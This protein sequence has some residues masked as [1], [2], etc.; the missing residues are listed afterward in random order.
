MNLLKLKKYKEIVV[1]GHS[2][3]DIDSIVSSKILSEILSNYGIKSHYAILSENYNLDAYNKKMINDC[4]EYNPVVINKKDIF[5]YNFFLVDHN[6]PGQSVGFDASIVGCIDHH[7]DIGKIKN[8]VF[9]DYCC[10]ALYIYDFFKDKYNFNKKQKRQIFMA[11]LNDSIFGKSSRYKESDEIVAQTL[12]FKENYNN[13]FKKY[14]IPTDLSKGI[15]ESFNNGYKIFNFDSYIIKSSYIESFDE[16]GKEEYLELIKNYEENFFGIWI[17]Y[18]LN[19]TYV[20]LKYNE[21]FTTFNYDFIASRATTIIND[22][23]KYVNNFKNN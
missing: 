1:I 6:D 18:S 19:K 2:K 3:P 12:G 8:A 14:F 7:I 4:M 22:V 15:K 5:D 23:V 10:T 21:Y 17:N 20:Y 9:T 16:V 13:L 11:F